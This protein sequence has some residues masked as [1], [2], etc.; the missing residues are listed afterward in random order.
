[1]LDRLTELD[2][3]APV[4][5][6]YSHLWTNHRGVYV[7]CVTLNLE[8]RPHVPTASKAHMS[9]GRQVCRT[10]GEEEILRYVVADVWIVRVF[11]AF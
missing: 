4:Q 10:I 7:C 2:I 6:V 8:I 3:N 1:M 5:L 9:T 11:N